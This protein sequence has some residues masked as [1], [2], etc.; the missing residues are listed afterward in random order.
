MRTVHWRLTPLQLD[1]VWESLAIGELPFPLQVQS[2]GHDDVERAH[3]RTRARDEL[4]ATGP[5]ENDDLVAALISLARNEYS[6]DSVWI[7]E[8]HGHSP[9]RVLTART[10]SR[11][12]LAVQLPGESEHEGGDLMLAS[13]RPEAMVVGV[14]SELPPAP[15]GRHPALAVPIEQPTRQDDG[16]DGFLVSSSSAYSRADR[17]RQLAEQLVSASHLRAGELGV[18]CRD[19]QGNRTRSDMLRW[20]DNADDG[21]YLMITDQRYARLWPAD[22]TVLGDTLLRLAP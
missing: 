22:A 17:E 18:T 15:P 4:R 6:I 1:Y 16:Q 14:I 8:E 3:L 20:F 13:I 5:H 21:R 19:R 9:M 12:T 11:A 10:G 7:A 2:H